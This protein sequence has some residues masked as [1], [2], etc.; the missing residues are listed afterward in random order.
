MSDDKET[1]ALNDIVALLGK[2]IK[3]LVAGA[4]EQERLVH[5]V[6]QGFGEVLSR[7][8]EMHSEETGHLQ[9]RA[10]AERAFGLVEDASVILQS[11]LEKAPPASM[12][13]DIHEQAPSSDMLEERE[14]TTE[15]QPHYVSKTPINPSSETLANQNAVVP[16]VP[17]DGT[18]ANQ[19]AV[20]QDEA[21]AQK[22]SADNVAENDADVPSVPEPMPADEEGYS[23]SQVDDLSRDP[24]HVPLEGSD[25][26]DED[27][28]AREVVDTS[29]IPTTPAPDFFALYDRGN[30]Q[31]M[32]QEIASWVEAGQSPQQI[33]DHYVS[34]GIAMTMRVDIFSRMVEE[35]VAKAEHQ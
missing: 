14:L 7:V 20:V 32:I 13:E 9:Y 12:A 31:A 29:D 18:L 24:D 19:N 17:Q 15:G 2:D 6:E 25:Q 27:L 22:E 33:Y 8:S 11:A 10:E 3:S 30:N 16:P 35:I 4:R 5:R 23:E 34:A 21:L 28:P 1:S 26:D